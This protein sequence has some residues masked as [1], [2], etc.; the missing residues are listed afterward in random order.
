MGCSEIKPR[1][2]TASSM[3]RSGAQTQGVLRQRSLSSKSGAVQTSSIRY[4]ESVDPKDAVEVCG[5][6]SFW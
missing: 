3:T 4:I 2:V 1:M 6:L 5:I